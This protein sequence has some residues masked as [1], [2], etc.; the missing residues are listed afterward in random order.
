M[1]KVRKPGAPGKRRRN[2]E[3]RTTD[4]DPNESYQVGYGRPPQHRQFRPGQSGN[5]KGRPKGSK[6]AATKARAALN[7][8]V[9]V[10]LNGKKSQM[11]VDDIAFRRMGDKAMAGDQKAHSYLLML[12]DDV[13]PSEIK[14]SEVTT[15]EQ[16]LEIITDYI[17]RQQR[18]EKVQ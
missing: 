16:D 18:K 5:P 8:K 11:T 17:R 15:T 10:T 13:D 2:R 14:S 12:A 1:R 9:T 6:N 7:R 3:K 4:V